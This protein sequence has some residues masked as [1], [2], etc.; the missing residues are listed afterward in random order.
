MT[1]RYNTGKTDANKYYLYSDAYYANTDGNGSGTKVA[2]LLVDSAGRIIN[3]TSA[4][5]SLSITLIVVASTGVM[6]LLLIAGIY[7]FSR[8]KRKQI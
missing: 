6:T 2:P 3:P 7:V 1:A 8:K 5:S 4:Q